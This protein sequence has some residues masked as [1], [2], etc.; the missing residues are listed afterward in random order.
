MWRADARVAY[1]FSD[2]Q[3]KG[4]STCHGWRRRPRA[5]RSSVG[6]RIV[7][8][9]MWR[10]SPACATLSP[11]RSWAMTTDPYDVYAAGSRSGSGRVA[12]FPQDVRL[13]AERQESLSVHASPWS[14][15]YGPTIP[16]A[17][18]RCDPARLTLTRQRIAIGAT[19]STLGWNMNGRLEAIDPRD[20]SPDA[21]VAR[22]AA[23]L[24]YDRPVGKPLLP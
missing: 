16:A 7:T 15:T 24:V 21:L 4:D 2:Q 18:T 5:S 3:F 10:R 20:G 19:G 13:A 23:S 1:G 6:G 14:S 9:P 22:V 8:R 12:R 17:R 11:R